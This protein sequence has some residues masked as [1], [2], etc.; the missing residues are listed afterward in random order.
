MAVDGIVSDSLCPWL[1]WVYISY[2]YLICAKTTMEDDARHGARV[3]R[4]E[5]YFHDPIVGRRWR[6]RCC[7]SYEPASTGRVI[8]SR[9]RFGVVGSRAN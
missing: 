7:V 9:T 2:F 5:I 3:V 4:I 8:V 6:R 1:T